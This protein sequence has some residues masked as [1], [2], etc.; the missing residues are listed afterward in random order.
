MIRYG[1]SAQSSKAVAVSIVGDLSPDQ[2]TRLSQITERIRKRHRAQ[3]QS[4]LDTGT[5]LLKV[6]G[7]L[8]HGAFVKW[9]EDEFDWTR[10]TAFRYMNAATH[11][12]GKCNIVLHLSPTTIYELAAPS[13]PDEVR[14]KLV[15][16]LE[17]G[18]HV[19]SDQV[20]EMAST[21][22][23]SASQD[24]DT[25][26]QRETSTPD[27]QEGQVEM[28]DEPRQPGLG[29]D[30]KPLEIDGTA[31][32]ISSSV[33]QP[34]PPAEDGDGSSHGAVDDKVSVQSDLVDDYEEPAPPLDAAEEVEQPEPAE[35]NVTDV[36]ERIRQ[37]RQDK[38]VSLLVAGLGDN[39]TELLNLMSEG[40]WSAQ[41]VFD[42]LLGRLKERSRSGLAW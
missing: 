37:R 14:D 11:F 34:D 29:D 27:A 42:D 9:L 19:T 15:K 13:T 36:A 20:K 28:M 30:G 32:L 1:S 10:Q 6:K 23:A 12:G 8:A 26:S 3:I 25:S 31:E 22:K 4:I 18:E 7:M 33:V 39:E 5:D 38:I 2:R 35:T 17:K 16:R 40:Q 24:E 21:A 41:S